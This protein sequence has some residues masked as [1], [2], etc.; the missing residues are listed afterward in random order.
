MKTITSEKELF[1]AVF[2]SERSRTPRAEMVGKR[3]ALVPTWVVIG[4]DD[5]PVRDR[6]I[7][8]A[9]EDNHVLEITPT[10]KRREIAELFLE[11]EADD[12]AD[13]E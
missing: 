4:L 5:L 7:L 2:P 10:T 11:P 12:C 8:K 13:G 9:I 1:A 3:I 6:Q